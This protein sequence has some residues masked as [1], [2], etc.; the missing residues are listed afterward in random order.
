LLQSTRDVADL[1]QERGVL[2]MDMD[3]VYFVG[4]VVAGVVVLVLIMYLVYKQGIAMCM[5]MIVTGCALVAAGL[6]FSLGKEGIALAKWRIALAVGLPPVVGLWMLLSRQVVTPTQ[7]MVATAT[8][9][10]R[11]ELDQ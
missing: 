5:G 8:A 7:Q 1:I 4:T 10:T 2:E 9:I 3:Y 6:C 11:E